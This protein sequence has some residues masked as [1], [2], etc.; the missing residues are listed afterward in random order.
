MDGG[1]PGRKSEGARKAAGWLDGVALMV[2]LS[3]DVAK[4]PF[5]SPCI[6]VGDMASCFY[7]EFIRRLGDLR[8]SESS[9]GECV[10]VG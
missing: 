2:S 1:S 7:M 5:D 9:V 4:V 3:K 8:M 6:C 10:Q